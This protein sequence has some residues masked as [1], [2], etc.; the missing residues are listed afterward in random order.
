MMQ[1]YWIEKAIASISRRVQDRPDS[2]HLIGL[3]L[4]VGGFI[5]TVISG[6]ICYYAEGDGPRQKA[7]IELF[8][9]SM[10]TVLVGGAALFYTS[11]KRRVEER[12]VR[13]NKLES[14]RRE[15]VQTYNEIKNHRRDLRYC[16]AGKSPAIDLS[17]YNDIMRSLNNTQLRLEDFIKLLAT[18]PDYF[19]TICIDGQK[20]L[21]KA[22]RYLR[23]VTHDYE[24]RSLENTNTINDIPNAKDF[25]SSVKIKD[26]VTSV[27]SSN[28]FGPMNRFLTLLNN[29]MDAA[30]Q[31]PSSRMQSKSSENFH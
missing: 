19:G 15:F 10:T 23:S 31:N 29:E 17:Q 7:L 5:L 6:L 18:K 14:F 27:A 11:H 4:V 2:E 20:L 26:G 24:R 3:L 12:A 8:K 9:F 1:P 25:I 16:L 22:E 30:S 28:F 13:R 21:G